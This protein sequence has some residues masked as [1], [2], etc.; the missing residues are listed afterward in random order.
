MPIFNR[1]GAAISGYLSPNGSFTGDNF[2]YFI[3]FNEND[4]EDLATFSAKLENGRIISASR[5]KIAGQQYDGGLMSFKVENEVEMEMKPM[6]LP[7]E[8]EDFEDV[9]LM[10]S[11]K[12]R[13]ETEEE[14]DPFQ[15]I[16]KDEFNSTDHSSENEIMEAGGESLCENSLAVKA[17]PEG[18]FKQHAFVSPQGSGAKWMLRLVELSTG[19]KDQNLQLSEAKG[20]GLF[21]NT[22]HERNVASNRKPLSPRKREPFDWRMQNLARIGRRA[23][24]LMRDP[25]ESIVSSW[26]QRWWITMAS[27]GL[28]SK[29]D[30]E[31]SL[32]TQAFRDFAE[33]ELK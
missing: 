27:E 21:L 28:T 26:T 8:V 10:Q 24:L 16:L 30:S 14:Q 22:H 5:A 7:P 23:V 29:D 17:F 12:L 2:L 11:T 15:S 19:I 4:N 25:Y 31:G 13:L 6:E 32:R 9:A 20:E 1:S 3:S 18:T 33:N